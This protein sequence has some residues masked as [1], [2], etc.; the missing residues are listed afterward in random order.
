MGNAER[1]MAL[2][3]SEEHVCKDGWS[4]LCLSEAQ[5]QTAGAVAEIITIPMRAEAADYHSKT[6]DSLTAHSVPALSYS[7]IS[8]PAIL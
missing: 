8:F 2:A 6:R 4:C 5:P 1:E 3:E 7:G